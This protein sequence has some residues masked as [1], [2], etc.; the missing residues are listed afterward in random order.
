MTRLEAWRF[1][2]SRSFA[3]GILFAIGAG[4]VSSGVSRSELASASEFDSAQTAS[5]QTISAAQYDPNYGESPAPNLSITVNQT[6]NLTSQ[7]VFVNWTGGKV[8][9]RASATTGGADFLQ[10]AQCWG[11]DPRNANRP[12]RTTCVYGLDQSP[13]ASRDVGANNR[14][15]APD[16]VEF[17]TTPQKNSAAVYWALP[18]N[19][20]TGET[21][22]SINTDP[23][24]GVKTRN[25]DAPANDNQFFT[26]Y[27]TNFV[28]WAGSSD[29]GS[30]SIKFEVQTNMQ[31]PGLGCGAPMTE[32][33]KSKGKSC[34][35]VIIPRGQSENGQNYITT[36]GLMSQSWAHHIAF[37]LNFK[38]LGV[39]CPIGTTEVQTVGGELITEAMASWQP[40][41]CKGASSSAFVIGTSNEQDALVAARDKQDAPLTLTSYP[42]EEGNDG[43]TYLPVAVGGIAISIALD[44]NAPYGSAVPRRI[45]SKNFTPIDNINLTPRLIAKLLTASYIAALP[46]GDRS[47]LGYYNPANQGANAPCLTKD[48]DFL[49]V[50]DSEWRY[51]N[52][53]STGT[54]DLVFPLGRSDMAE[55]LWDY[56]L[57]DKDARDFLS[58]TPD[59]WGMKVNPW[60][61][62]NDLVNPTGT[63]TDYPRRE[64]PKAD[65]IEVSGTLDTDPMFGY[66]PINLVT[67]RPY[68]NDF[69]SDA[70][71]VLRGDSQLLGQWNSS[72]IPKKWSRVA[73]KPPGFQQTLAITSTGAAS[74]YGNVV[75]SLQNSAGVFVKPTVDAMSAAQDAF[76]PQ[77]DSGIVRYISNSLQAIENTSAYP[78]TMPIYASVN[79]KK[80]SSDLLAKYLKYISYALTQG[81]TKGTEIGQLPSGYSPLSTAL[82]SHGLQQLS[83]I[84]RGFDP[85]ATPIP[86]PTPEPTLAPTEVPVPIPTESP[87]NNGVEF[88]S[89][90]PRDPSPGNLSQSVPISFTIG[91][92]A[93][94]F[95]ARLSRRASRSRK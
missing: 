52:V 47:H 1:Y 5:A 80:T 46:L 82:V 10:I 24:T 90:T 18:F 22:N 72:S 84:S 60:F 8:S 53:C 79:V 17:A 29:N 11:D 56:V 36:P 6:N 28:P 59:P 14:N 83:L 23:A 13:G 74:R 81:Q 45:T 38:P 58:G 20:F 35:L 71:L 76:T 94:G 19:S 75:A 73:P 25:F 16:D 62:S 32:G 42:L 57:A 31:S 49:S 40:E 54:S 30:G 9:E 15:L 93:G 67:W 55:M 64:F 12:D 27:T 21:N 48:P 69:Q 50:N 33:G 89:K 41:L 61:S 63:A 51:Q 68:T 44:R 92:V 34:W 77:G 86:T 3:L 26:R 70:L 2:S 85:S 66:G 88:G 39:N 43:L 87:S 65:P 4:I 95:W 7:A 91:T 37:R 78:L